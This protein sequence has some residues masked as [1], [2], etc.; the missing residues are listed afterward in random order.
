MRFTVHAGHNPDGK[1]A[2]GAV[3]LIKESTENRKVKDEVAG[4]LKRGDKV[5]IWSIDKDRKGDDWGSFRYS[6]NPDIIGY[7]H[8]DYLEGKA[9]IETKK[10]K[11]SYSNGYEENFSKKALQK[12]SS[13][14]I[15][16]N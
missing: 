4:K 16:R 14:N 5:E 7:V 8:M 9:S 1:K 13:T 2:C 10:V 6:F 12:R 15:Y 3:G 11:V